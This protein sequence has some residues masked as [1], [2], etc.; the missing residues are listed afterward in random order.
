MPSTAAPPANPWVDYSGRHPTPEER[1]AAMAT[2]DPYPIIRIGETIFFITRPEDEERAMAEQG[3]G[4]EE[5][6]IT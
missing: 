3:A 4:S 1:A 5:S 6:R 2:D